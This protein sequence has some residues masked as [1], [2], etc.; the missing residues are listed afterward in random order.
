MIASCQS[1]LTTGRIA[2]A[3]G[4]F[5]GIHQVAPVYTPA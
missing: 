2:I 4:R 5:S 3:H 1:N